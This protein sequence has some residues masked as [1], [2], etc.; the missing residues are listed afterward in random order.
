MEKLRT[1]SNNN[2]LRLTI[3]D[4]ANEKLEIWGDS[5]G[6]GN[7]GGAGRKLAEV[8][9][10][11]TIIHRGETQLRGGA[12]VEG[13]LKFRHNGANGND[14]SDPYKIEK[15]RNGNNNHVLR[16]TINDDAAEQFQIY[17]DSCRAGNCGGPGRRL[18]AVSGHSR[19]NGEQHAIGLRHALAV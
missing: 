6:A 19:F 13:P 10:T 5:C 18:F 3:N 11:G 14:G 16:M 1:G 9:P 4:D 8:S 7:C 12:S 17:G 2:S 15:L